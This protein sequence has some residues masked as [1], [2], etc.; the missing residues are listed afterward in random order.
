LRVTRSG[1]SAKIER[2]DGNQ[3]A[4]YAQEQGPDPPLPRSPLLR[5]SQLARARDRQTIRLAANMQVNV[6]GGSSRRAELDR[7][8]RNFVAA[9]D[10]KAKGGLCHDGSWDRA[11]T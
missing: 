6:Q 1:L 9:I 8:W 2:H 11:L 3:D 4:R 5:A 7:R 10:D